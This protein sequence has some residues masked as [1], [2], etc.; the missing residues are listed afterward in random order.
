MVGGWVGWV[1]E[2]EAVGMSCY[3][4]GEE[5]EEEEEE[6]EEAYLDGRLLQNTAHREKR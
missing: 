6:D 1:K 2:N 3:G 5:E 4:F